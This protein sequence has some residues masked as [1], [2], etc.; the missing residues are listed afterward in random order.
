[1]LN[2][3]P[4]LVSYAYFEGEGDANVVDRK[5]VALLEEVRLLRPRLEALACYPASLRRQPF[6]CSA[7]CGH[8]ESRPLSRLYPTRYCQT[9]PALKCRLAARLGPAAGG[10]VFAH[11]APTTFFFYDVRRSPAGTAQERGIAPEELVSGGTAHDRHLDKLN[12]MFRAIHRPQHGSL[13]LWGW[14]TST[15]Y[16]RC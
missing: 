16:D 9:Y 14:V 15:P 8:S 13:S 6:A 1:M 7:V 4:S 3:S 10:F 11:C 5:Q 12:A 2:Q